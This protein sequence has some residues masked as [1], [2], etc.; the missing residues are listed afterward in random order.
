LSYLIGL[1]GPTFIALFLFRSSRSPSLGVYPCQSIVPLDRRRA[2]LES[3]LSHEKMVDKVPPEVLERLFLYVSSPYD[4]FTLRL[5]CRQWHALIT[6]ERF[7]NL[8][9]RKRLGPHTGQQLEWV[10][11]E[12][13]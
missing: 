1:C 5:V 12:K 11:L 8:Y 9:F 13:M 10:N 3:D 6:N 2:H 7:L 4:L